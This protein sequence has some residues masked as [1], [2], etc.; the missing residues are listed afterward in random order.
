MILTLPGPGAL[1][2]DPS[3]VVLT[4]EVVPEL[5][6][7]VETEL[8]PAASLKQ[9]PLWK[10]I[11]QLLE[12]PY[13]PVER[14]P[15]FRDEEMPPL[16]TYP[17]DR[18][19]LT[20]QPLRLRTSDGEISWDQ[21]GFLY[22]P[23]E[24]DDPEFM[25]MNGTPMQPRTVIG[26]LVVEY[27]L[28]IDGTPVC[29]TGTGGCLVVR[30]PAVNGDPENNDN[31]RT[32]ASDEIPP[33]GTIVAVPAYF[34]GRQHQWD[35]EL[36]VFEEIE[37][38]EEEDIPINEEDFLRDEDDTKGVKRPLWEFVGRHGA[39]V[40]GKALFWDMQ[41]GSDGTQACGSCH[42]HAGVDNR[43][44]NQ[45]NPNTTGGD[46]D[47]EVFA[48]RTTP[49]ADTQN[50][51]Q[52]VVASDFPF[53]KL[54]DLD[55][56][57]ES[58]DPNTPPNVKS[59]S[60]DVMSSMGVSRFKRFVDIPPIGKAS[61]LPAVKVGGVKVKA[62]APDIGIEEDDPVP[63]LQ[64]KR[65]IE[66]RHTPTFHAA[67]FNFDNFWD[68]RARFHFNGGSVFGPSDPQY[69]IFIRAEKN[70]L[71]PATNGHIRPGLEEEKPEQADQPVRIKFSSLAS[72]AVGP[73]LSEFEMS[74][75]GRSWP[76]IGKKLLQKGVRPLANQLVAVDDSR[77]GPF[78]NQGG[79]VCEALGR[80]TATGAPGL[81]TSYRELIKL[82]FDRDFW[83]V[84]GKHLKGAPD[85]DDPFDGYSLSGPYPGH[86]RRHDT[87]EFTQME[88]NFSLFF[89]LAVQMYEELV[90][91]DDT[92]FDRFMDANPM[93]GNGVGQ[94]GESRGRFRPP[95]SA[96]S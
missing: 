29:A 65:R 11:I 88:A 23:D 31:I 8:G 91:P 45:L 73:P 20:G 13:S 14:R 15:S 7:E 55:G 96:G 27:D 34:D 61:F 51:N 86:A 10:E 47:L 67:A 71:V 66:P 21:P 37:E 63:V 90:I 62:L 5:P 42:F 6:V 72:Q 95:R 36:K 69:H 54:H 3:N 19:V 89:G 12:D 93:A 25:F 58:R 28:M 57:S 84:K 53:H 17:L 74:F 75:L 79:E 77:L 16:N 64:G 2:A 49:P 92:P 9:A 82:T 52:D 18:N 78:S 80:P 26:E 85:V 48:N 38:I 94:P 76:K 68:G 39:E 35:P 43:T 32:E 40:L 4:P 46:L 30:N 44:R 87:N 50:P 83:S 24:A 33:D 60:N 56:L 1:A 41:V 59:D 81:C 70:T 22:D